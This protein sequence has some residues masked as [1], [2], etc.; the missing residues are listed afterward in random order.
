MKIILVIALV[1]CTGCQANLFSSDEPKPQLEQLT[2]AFRSYFERAK[3]RTSQLGQE[4]NQYTTNLKEQMDPLAKELMTKIT[5]GADMLK[6]R[7]EVEVS[8]VRCALKPY[9]EYVT[10]PFEKGAEYIRESLDFDDLKATVL[11]KSEELRESLEQGTK[12]LQAKLEPST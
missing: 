7:I 3:S 8:T 1:V 9:I 11:Q 4:I 5:K 12:E 6:E 10:S 2:D